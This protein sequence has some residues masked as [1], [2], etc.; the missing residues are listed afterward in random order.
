MSGMTAIANVIKF[1]ITL[2]ALV[3]SVETIVRLARMA[4]ALVIKLGQIIS[5]K[6][7]FNGFRTQFSF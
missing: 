1:I 5:R 7:M 2:A 4:W 6:A 3:G